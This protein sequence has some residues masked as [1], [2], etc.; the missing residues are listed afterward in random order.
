MIFEGGI[1]TNSRGE[2]A[3]T[4]VAYY[5][6]HIRYEQAVKL[7]L[8]GTKVLLLSFMAIFNLPER[9]VTDIIENAG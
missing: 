4:K 5:Q 2:L 9:I 1:K 6:V 7:F 3:N 8:A